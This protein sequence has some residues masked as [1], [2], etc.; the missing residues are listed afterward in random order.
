MEHWAAARGSSKAQDGSR[1][2]KHQEQIHRGEEPQFYLRAVNF[3]KSAL[4]RQ[5]G[6][7]V[8]IRRTG[9]EGAVL[10]SKAEFNRCY[11]PRL[12]M[13][14]EEEIKKGEEQMELELQLVVEG[15]RAEDNRWEQK[16]RSRRVAA[17]NR[18]SL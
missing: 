5:T 17:D 8:R 14:E 13:V 7:A 16:K 9:G 18:S 4:S 11:I 15:I 3:Y 10:N 12:H 1:I 2:H 6:E